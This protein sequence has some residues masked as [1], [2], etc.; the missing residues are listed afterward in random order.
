MD[1]T[2]LA[3]PHSLAMDTSSKMKILTDLKVIS[4]CSKYTQSQKKCTVESCIL[5]GVGEDVDSRC[6]F[7]VM[8]PWPKK[9]IIIKIKNN[10]DK[11]N[12]RTPFWPKSNSEARTYM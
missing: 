12:H 4:G 1:Q 10:K 6:R 2:R 9:K 8:H 11:S 3:S 5:G 7:N